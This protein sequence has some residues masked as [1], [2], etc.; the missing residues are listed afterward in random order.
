VGDEDGAG[1]TS[2]VLGRSH[3]HLPPLS[4]THKTST[5]NT[6]THTHT[7]T[8]KHD[9]HLE[10]VLEQLADSVVRLGDVGGDAARLL[11][12]VADGLLGALLEL[13][14]EAL[15]ELLVAGRELRRKGECTGKQEGG[16][17]R[18]GAR[19]AGWR[20]RKGEGC[21]AEPYLGDKACTRTYTLSHTLSLGLTC[22]VASSLG[23]R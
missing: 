3:T 17:E 14:V 15:V 8:P 10:Q 22:T 5:L 19:G 7:H 9:T 1:L 13:G 18:R 4:Y 12:C 6:H 2:R 20:R 11:D 21:K 23:G 16:G